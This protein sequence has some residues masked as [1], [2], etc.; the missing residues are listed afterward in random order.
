MRTVSV[1]DAIP[2]SHILRCDQRE[3]ISKEVKPFLD[4]GSE[5][6]EKGRNMTDDWISDTKELEELA[7]N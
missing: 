5:I 4:A 2:R 1:Y 7:G 3:A 6:D